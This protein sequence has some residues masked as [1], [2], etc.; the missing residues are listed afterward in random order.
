[1]ST[2]SAPDDHACDPCD[3]AGLERSVLAVAAPDDTL[4]SILHVGGA[5]VGPRRSRR[6][7]IAV[8]ERGVVV[9]AGVAEVVALVGEG[10]VVVA[11]A[12]VVDATPVRRPPSSTPKVLT[13]HQVVVA[14]GCRTQASRDRDGGVVVRDVRGRVLAAVVS[15]IPWTTQPARPRRR[16]PRCR[17]GVVRSPWGGVGSQD[18]EPAS[19][20]GRR[21][22]RCGSRQSRTATAPIG[23]G[24]APGGRSVTRSA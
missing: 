4:W 7:S 3:L 22:R 9:D 11:E 18:R 15:M 24:G 13:R 1:M 21:A 12:V 16:R 2:A 20:R 23:P 6:R 5:G 8:P 14:G 17:T 19:G 10:I